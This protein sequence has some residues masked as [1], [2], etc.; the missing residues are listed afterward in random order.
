MNN[1]DILDFC[2]QNPEPAYDPFYSKAESS[3]II[4]KDNGTLNDLQKANRMMIESISGISALMSCPED[5]SSAIDSLIKKIASILDSCDGINYSELVSYF[6]VNDVSF[7]VYSKL[8]KNDKLDFLSEIIK[9]YIKDRHSIYLQYGYTDTSLQSKADSFAHK[10]S[11][12]QGS[13][14]I[15]SILAS[16]H[17]IYKPI[18][19]YIQFCSASAC[20]IKPDLADAHLF[21]EILAKKR[22]R[23]D[24]SNAHIGKVPDFCI[25]IHDN[26][27][28]GEQKHMKESGGGQ[29]KQVVELVDFID[30]KE[31][32][33]YIKYISFLD[34]VLFNQIFNHPSK[35]KM[36]EQRSK[37]YEILNRNENSYFV[38]TAG[39]RRLI[40]LASSKNL[41]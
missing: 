19:T 6:S 24:W 23:F 41:T 32:S 21:K 39:F 38:N 15:E 34:G 26:I 18:T 1:L 29:D 17:V 22:I 25:K 28:I 13:S 2:T 40:S 20:Y 3:L 9:E 27:L 35:G 30:Q 14:K 10:K 33:N 5:N 31:N 11:G 36:E 8:S 37:I 7:S 16:M 12:P 4:S